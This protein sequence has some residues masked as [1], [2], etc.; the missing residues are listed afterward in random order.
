MAVE[1]IDA[2]LATPDP[3]GEV[4]RQSYGDFTALEI[5]ATFHANASGEV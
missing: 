5:V 3:S 2:H 4:I 1:A